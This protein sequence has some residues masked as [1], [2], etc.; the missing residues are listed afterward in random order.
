MMEINNDL[1]MSKAEFLDMLAKL[2]RVANI[3]DHESNPNTDWTNHNMA[4]GRCCGHIDSMLRDFV[5][6]GTMSNYEVEKFYASL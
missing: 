6:V 2:Y 5:A 1:K 4:G 3:S